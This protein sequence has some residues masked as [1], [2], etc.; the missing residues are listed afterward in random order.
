MDA[1]LPNRLVG[2]GDAKVLFGFGQRQPE[3]TPEC[4]P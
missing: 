2:N 4:V 3:T 1:H